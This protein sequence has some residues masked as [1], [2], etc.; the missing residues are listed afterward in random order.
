MTL[1]RLMMFVLLL[2]LPLLAVTVALAAPRAQ[3]GS[4]DYGDSVSGRLDGT[5]D[6]WTFSG[7]IGDTI[8]IAMESR[9]FDTLLELIGPDGVRVAR[10]DDGGSGLN[11]LIEEFTLPT[12]G[13]Y[14]IIARGFELDAV[15][16]YTVTLTLASSTPIAPI[17]FGETVSGTLA[18]NT[19]LWTFGANAG[20]IV[21]IAMNSSDF[22]T[23]LELLG[24]EGEQI[25]TNDDGGPGLNS[26]LENIALPETG[27]YTIVAR[28]LSTSA[29]GD[30]TLSLQ[31]GVFET[32]PIGYGVSVTSAL[33]RNQE[34]WTF[35][36]IAGETITIAMTSDD[37]D[38][39][40]E[41]LGPDGTQVTFN[42]DSGQG[43]N[44]LIENFT[45]SATGEY[46]IIARSFGNRG[47]G[48]YTLS[49]SRGSASPGPS[50]TPGRG[51]SG[52]SIAYG[53][54][55]SGTLNEN[56]QLWTFTGTEGDVVTIAMT[57]SDF[58]TYLEL[59]GPN[60]QQVAFNDDGGQGL[61][62]LIENY[63]LPTSGTFTIV[64][65]SFGN[66]GRGNYTL[67]LSTGTAQ[68]PQGSGTITIGQT[69]T[70]SLNQ[71][72]QTWTF[73]GNAGDVISIEMNSTDFDTYLELNGPNGQ[74]VAFNDDGGPGLNSFINGFRLPTSGTY[75]IIARSFANAGRGTYTLTLT[76]GGVVV[77]TPTPFP[78]QP[79]PPS[80]DRGA[81]EF[82]QTV[83]GS[84]NQS[85]ERWTFTA[86]AGDVIT[87]E[88]NSSDFDTYLELHDA[89]EQQVAFNDDG[90][91][92]LN[93]L[94]NGFRIPRS[95]RYTIIARSF[96]NGGRGSYTLSLI[97][98]EVVV[99]TPTPF[100]TQPPPPSSSGGA[101]EFGQTV[102]GRINRSQE[103]W[104]FSA[105]AGDVISIEMNSSDFDTYLE[106]HDADG[107]QVTSNDDGGPG[108]NSLISGFAIPRSGRYTIVARSFGNGGS[109]SYT[110]TLTRGTAI[111]AS[112]T[113]L[114]T[115][116][117]SNQGSIGYGDTVTGSLNRSLDSW[118]FNG[119]AGDVVNIAMNSS[120]FD[121]YLE[122]YGP[123][124]Q[125]VTRNDDG[126]PGLNSLIENVT[127]PTSGTYT[128]IARS[129][130]NGG[131][132]SYTLSLTEGAGSSS[133]GGT[134]PGLGSADDTIAFGDTVTGTLNQSQ[135]AWTF[136]ANAGQIVT[137][138]MESDDFDTYLE[139]YAP[140]G[141]QATRDDDGGTGRNSFIDGFRL[142][143]SGTYTIVAR[144]FGNRGVGDYTLT[145]TGR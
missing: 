78:T 33:N 93:S 111:S 115:P 56:Q 122:L 143:V 15:G 77:P 113:P 35:S 44:S 126:G 71:S 2:A 73:S 1:R 31:V 140:D 64:A 105:N 116:A 4:L 5:Q 137:I 141:I 3:G 112:P 132:G 133:G 39:Y 55:V 134:G 131:R 142:P 12:T 135:D 29:S 59:L 119:S 121:T 89:D 8:T 47:E 96:A 50:P 92:G 108:L 57:S 11:S 42:D 88:M 32:N 27:T 94:I 109:G 62:S 85:Q 13:T 22:D 54:S 124:G 49:L 106:L 80:S 37:F 120:D 66:R 53:Q 16:S 46:T 34:R 72:Q 101:I 86:N 40:L 68:P 19:N 75:T 81:I 99:P 30:Y 145:L 79:P 129:F 136:T 51:G 118:T 20:D 63:T 130:G 38:T 123:D 6:E 69:V 127:L 60:G 76:A 114:P 52:G 25:A 117:S 43:L 90:G 98:G 102:T 23:Y 26:L 24:P 41:L 36:G 21:T 97:S 139:L 138:S 144:S 65:R 104:T 91:P 58:D 100:P 48:A 107:Q 45:L 84:L 9:D 74:Q 18:S 83:T 7:S 82:G 70:G 128:I 87:I 28:G 95:G 103:T 10:N 67:T 14:T 61:N 17:A 110:L 125:E